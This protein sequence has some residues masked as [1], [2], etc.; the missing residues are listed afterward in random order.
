MARRRRMRILMIGGLGSSGDAM[1][2]GTGNDVLI[3]GN[4]ENV[5]EGGTGSDVLVGGSLVNVMLSDESSSNT[6]WLLG[7]AGLNFEI[8]KGAGT[9]NLFDYTAP[10]DPLQTGAWEKVDALAMQ[11]SVQLP[12]VTPGAN[13]NA[14]QAYLNLETTQNDLNSEFAALNALAQANHPIQ[15]GTLTNGNNTVTNLSFLPG[16]VTGTT[17]GGLPQIQVMNTAFMLPNG[18]LQAPQ[19]GDLVSGIGIPAGTTVTSV[20]PPASGSDLYTIGLS[21]AVT[22]PGPNRNAQVTFSDP[23][24]VEPVFENGTL[25][26]GSTSVTG[27]SQLTSISGSSENTSNGYATITNISSTVGLAVGDIITGPGVPTGTTIE[28]IFD[29]NSIELSVGV[30]YA[31][32]N[33]T[34]FVSVPL[35][36]GQ[37]VTGNGIPAGTT[38]AAVGADGTSITLSQPAVATGVVTLSFGS[39]PF[40]GPGVSVPA[41][42]DLPNGDSVAAVISGTSVQLTQPATLPS[43]I[44][45]ATVQLNFQLTPQENDERLALDNTLQGIAQAESN[46]LSHLGATEV[47]D[48]LQGGSGINELYAGQ[49]PVW[50]IGSGG[51]DT[52]NITPANYTQFAQGT[53]FIDGSSA[54]TPISGSSENTGNGYATITNISSTVAL[55]AGDIITGPGIPMG[56]R[57]AAVLDQNSIELSAGVDYTVNNA[58]FF[59]SACPK[60]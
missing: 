12:S 5:L 3:G 58:T 48:F 38:I 9:E 4:G 42:S 54:N 47:E 41:S 8:G 55:A 17:V 45:T 26:S 30:E 18:E 23:I 16:P 37:P 27:L 43:G 35:H 24:V 50:M 60:H 22:Y 46:E 56:T 19:Q 33:S 36:V 32:N 21:N 11:L 15:Y 28:S 14:V 1:I 59:W 7:G 44:S 13:L 40:S 49:A 31:V 34:F 2:A 6:S 25:T 20:T 52:F 10:S 57:I 39:D 51:N 53:D 29:E